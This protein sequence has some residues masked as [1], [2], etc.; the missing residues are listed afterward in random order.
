MSKPITNKDKWIISLISALLFLLIASPYMFKLTNNLL[1]STGY[2]T[3]DM[4]GCPNTFG[5]VLHASVF[6]LVTRLLMR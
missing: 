3:C 2:S 1:S 5:L 4:R 6:L